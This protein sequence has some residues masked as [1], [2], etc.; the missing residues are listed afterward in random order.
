M[1]KENKEVLTG[2]D[3]YEGYNID[4][5]QHISEILGNSVSVTCDSAS[6]TER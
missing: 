6:D 1:Y 3:Q 5:I 2:N 4:L